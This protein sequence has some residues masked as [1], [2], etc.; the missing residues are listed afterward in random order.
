MFE[1][2]HKL[3]FIFPKFIGDFS[4]TQNF[5]K[6][7]H[8]NIIIGQKYPEKQNFQFSKIEIGPYLFNKTEME[9]K[10]M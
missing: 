6:N 10:I 1:S 4:G 7:I 5:V 9:I 2:S 8:R 3:Y